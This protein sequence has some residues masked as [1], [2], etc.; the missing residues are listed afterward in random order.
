MKILALSGSPRKR[1]TAAA[2]AAIHEHFPEIDFEILALKDLDLKLCK[3]CYTCITRGEERCPLKD[4]RD[5][6]LRK[7][8]NADGLILGS[9]TYSH[10]VPALM[11]NLFDRLGYLAHRPHFL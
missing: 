8:E 7:I 11:K 1:N 4:D 9:P 10:M 5:M 6:L 3:G 2:L